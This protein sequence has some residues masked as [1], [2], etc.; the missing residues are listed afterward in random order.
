[1]LQPRVGTHVRLEKLVLM[2]VARRRRQCGCVSVNIILAA[3]VWLAASS[4]RAAPPL[5]EKV[6]FNKHIRPIFA[7]NCFLCHG[8]DKGTRKAGLRLDERGFALRGVN[9]RA[10]IIPGN[11]AASELFKRIT[12]TDPSRAM[13]ALGDRLSPWQIALIKKWINDGANY[14]PH[15]SYLTPQKKS[16]PSIHHPPSAIR[17]PI[18]AFILAELDK[19]DLS[20]SAEADRRTLIR[21]LSF[22]LTGLP[23]T[24][25]EVDT[26][27]NDRSPAAYEELVERL[28][29]S[30][31]YGE[32]MAVQWLDLV[33]YADTVGYHGDQ[34]THVSPY[35]DYVITAFNQN[36]PFDRFTREQLAGDLLPGATLEQKIAS[37]YNRLNM[38]TREGGAQA[39][40][41]LAKYAAD[42][43]RTTSSVWL[44]ATLGCAQ[45]HDHKFDPYT[46]KDFYSF[47][48]FF[49]DV[50]EEG[51]Y[52]PSA[53]YAR[54]EP[55]VLLASDGQKKRLAEMDQQL[56]ALDREIAAA[57]KDKAAVATLKKKRGELQLQRDQY[58]GSLP[59]CVVTESVP[60]R[61]VRILP[62]GNWMD[63]SG[64]IVRPAV[65][66]FLPQPANAGTNR[67]TR[68]DL[69]NWLVARDNPITARVIVNRLWKLCFGAGLS[70]VLDD[71]GNRGEWPRHLDLLDWLAVEFMDSGW[72]MKHMVR[73]M[74]TSATYRQAS[75]PAAKLKE[76]DPYNRLYARQSRSRLEAEFVRD[77]A[78]AISGL[79]VPMVGGPSVQPYQPADYYKELNFPRR[80]YTSDQGENQYR[81]GLYTHWQRTFLHPSLL[82]FDAPPREECVAERTVSNTPLQA[83]TLLNDPTYVEAARVFAARIIEK[84]GDGFDARL[85][86]AW[87]RALSR[88]P[89]EKEAMA[90]KE[91]FEEQLA[92]FKM[93]AN[94]ARQLLMVGNAPTPEKLDV[95][96][97]AAWTSVSRTIL[98]LHETIVRY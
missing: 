27:E 94:A 79:L 55:A 76:V 47:A 67:L 98:N 64:E 34:D 10:A 24:P 87:R 50:K 72:D 7:D 1:M 5:P 28:L 9:G 2:A 38:V 95:V 89:T 96:E 54:F 77:N 33:R 82:A 17:N 43:V 15:W 63:D 52:T 57:G 91:L 53:F 93:N 39:K 60:P 13:P 36:L 71:L 42:R 58:D 30:K 73:L 85:R 74:V 78:L 48:A 4:G 22:D 69:A 11:A 92:G 45:C 59:A 81:R 40:E 16:P 83:L 90:M 8:H 70:K 86:W 80:T 65:P 68:L 12:S 19:E 84:G 35:R 66:H 51:V 97:L 18:D 88:P 32:R 44:G 21:R 46:M 26:F 62:R 56:A 3:M 14:E 6:G 37:A 25:E 41:Y 20:P 49:A 29:A 23:P 75:K 61:T 31:H